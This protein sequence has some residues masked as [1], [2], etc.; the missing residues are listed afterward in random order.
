M[1]KIMR[2]GGEPGMAKDVNVQLPSHF[3]NHLSI[4]NGQ[5]EEVPFI[6]FNSFLSIPDIIGTWSVMN[7]LFEDEE[8][9][10]GIEEDRIKP[11]IWSNKWIPFTDYEASSRLILDLDPGKNGISGQFKDFYFV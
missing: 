7:E 3:R 6:G 1:M 10:E 11:L 8:E 9:A 2:S 4:W 5:Q